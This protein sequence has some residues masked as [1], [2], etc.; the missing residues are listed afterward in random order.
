[1]KSRKYSSKIILTSKAHLWDGYRQ[2][3]GTL[4]LTEQ[5][6]IFEFDDFQGSHLNLII[7]L[8]DI[9]A[10]KH[11]LVFEIGKNGLKVTS[12]EGHDLFLLEEAMSFR[13]ILLK[14]ISSGKPG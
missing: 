13:S 6:L 4:S 12:K 11:F 5:K 3:P 14:A 2:L 10:V 8:A 9:E 1:M 7:S